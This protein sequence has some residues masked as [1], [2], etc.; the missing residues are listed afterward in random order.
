MTSGGSAADGPGGAVLE[1][2]ARAE[3]AAVTDLWVVAGLRAANRQDVVDVRYHVDPAS[4]GVA[5]SA[6]TA[7]AWEP[8]V[9]EQDAARLAVVKSVAAWAGTAAE[10]LDRGLRGRLQAVSLPAITSAGD[11]EP[12][13]VARAA[14]VEALRA[15]RES[16]SI[17]DQEF[18]SQLA[19]V[20]SAAAAAAAAAAG[21]WTYAQVAGW[22][23][24]TY[25]VV[26][27][28]INAGIDYVFIGRPFAA[29]VLVVLQVVVNT[30]K[31]FFH[32]MMWQEIFGISPLQ[33]DAPNVIEFGRIVTASAN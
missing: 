26:V 18:Q 33:R 25:R 16:G 31:F 24:F 20:D 11:L 1:T 7:A 14:R 28:T 30:T 2:F 29:G 3:N 4:L 6:A 22:K 17:S 23:A 5:A 19:D 15:L 8:A 32:E 9:I 21:G 10:P 27:T 13:A 12:E